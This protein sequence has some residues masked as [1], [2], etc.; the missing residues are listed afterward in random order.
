VNILGNYFIFVQLTPES[1]EKRLVT[2]GATDGYRTEVLSGV[3][4]GERVV[5]KG[6]S[7]VRLA[8][9]GAAL[10]PHAGHVH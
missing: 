10:D 9:N 2:L 4:P 7:M 6:A 8:Q 1:F 5:T 3:E